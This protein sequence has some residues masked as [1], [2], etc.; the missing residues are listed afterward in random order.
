MPPGPRVFPGRGTAIASGPGAMHTPSNMTI[1]C[2]TVDVEEH[3]QV[4]AFE[5]TVSRAAWAEMASRVAGNVDRLLAAL[6]RHCG[7]TPAQDDKTLLVMRYVP[8]G[9]E[10]PSSA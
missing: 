8:S 5:P 9:E 4:S 1:H 7:S 10:R 3:F 6:D 2:F